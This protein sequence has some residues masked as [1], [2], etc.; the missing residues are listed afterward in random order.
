MKELRCMYKKMSGVALA[1]TFI[2]T[3]MLY[4]GDRYVVIGSNDNYATV[5]NAAKRAGG[6]V[7]NQLVYDTAFTVDLDVAGA[8]SLANQFGDTIWIERDGDAR[9]AG[10]PPPPPPPQYTAWY[11]TH[12][13]GIQTQAA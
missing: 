10:K 2:G 4:A 11:H 3:S 7:Q 13:D 9:M 1:S 12:V 6:R 5:F 8:N